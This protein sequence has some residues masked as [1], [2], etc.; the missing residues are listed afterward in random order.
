M[1]TKCKLTIP[2][3]IEEMKISID[4]NEMDI[5]DEEEATTISCDKGI[6]ADNGTN[7]GEILDTSSMSFNYCS[8]DW[9]HQFRQKHGKGC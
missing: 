9:G 4:G 8:K 7:C 2:S 1:K 5:D 6:L 3:L